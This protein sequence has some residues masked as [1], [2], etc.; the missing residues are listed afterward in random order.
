MARAWSAADIFCD[1]IV[2]IL[3]DIKKVKIDIQTVGFTVQRCEAGIPKPGF[4]VMM[5]EF[6]IRQTVCCVPKAIC[7]IPKSVPRVPK[8]ISQMFSRLPEALPVN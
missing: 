1:G 5:D 3:F 8:A 7:A 4:R 2:D 6:T